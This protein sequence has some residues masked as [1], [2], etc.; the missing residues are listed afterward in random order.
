MSKTIKVKGGVII[1][2]P[3]LGDRDEWLKYHDLKPTRSGKVVVFKAVDDDFKSGH[4]W[5]Y[6][7]G[8]KPESSTWKPTNACGDGLHF[9][10]TPHHALRYFSDATRFV[11]C[12]IEVEHLTPITDS[13]GSSDKCKAPRALKCVEVSIDGVAIKAT[14]PA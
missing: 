3:H 8:A 2:R 13:D 14:E 4:R 12:T 7:P 6:S 9:S 1:D 5:D 10:P 11:A